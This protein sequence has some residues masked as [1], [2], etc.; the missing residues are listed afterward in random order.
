MSNYLSIAMV[1]EALRQRIA[2][3]V[4][5]VS[6]FSS[7]PEVRA[8]RPEKTGT[9]YVG[10]NIYLYQLSPNAA[11]RNND[12]PTRFGASEFMQRPAAALDL[13]FLLSF[14]GDDSR[15]E[16][17][18]LAG[19]VIA[20]LHALPVL[21][22]E[23]LRSV[24]VA[25]GPESPLA[26]ADLDQEPRTVK[27]TPTPLNIEELSKLWTVFFQTTHALSYAYRAS[28]ILIEAP[29]ASAPAL[30][31]RGP[32]LNPVPSSGLRLEDVVPAVLAYSPGAGIILRGT[33]PGPGDLLVR[34][35]DR[36]IVPQSLLDGTL[37]V[38]LP[39]DGPAGALPVRVVRR[40]QE[41]GGT[42]QETISNAKQLLAQP[43]LT[44]PVLYRKL[45]DPRTKQEADAVVV[46]LSPVPGVGQPLELLLNPTPGDK[47]PVPARS[48]G[49]SSAW[50]FPLPPDLQ[51]VLEMGGLP[52]ALCEAFAQHRLPLDGRAALRV[53]QPGQLWL[54]SSRG[55][56]SYVIRRSHDGLAVYLGLERK[57]FADGIV[58]GVGAM[59][60]GSYLVRV[61]LGRVPGVESALGAD[62]AGNYVRPVVE[63]P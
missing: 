28:A 3:A 61:H 19:C 56:D 30:P 48:Y 40:Q 27:F 54:I 1:T 50:R 21:T 25:A 2:Q 35:G 57:F 9:P 16:P 33:W 60:P 12:L 43:L 18:R 20:A 10:V 4:S 51:P 13:D 11:L 6:R 15:L 29:V 59:L 38:E 53:L 39:A 37:R 8:G 49:V 42:P 17:Q 7:A 5:G 24:K 34:L 32:A 26:E 22:A 44:E 31:V 23:F 47:A 52:T 58:F 55:G 46:R 45:V 14:H 62:P 63:V 41:A 36:D